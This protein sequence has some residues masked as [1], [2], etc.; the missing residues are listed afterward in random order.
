LGDEFVARK[1]VAAE[2]VEHVFVPLAKLGSQPLVVAAEGGEIFYSARIRVERPMTGEVLDHGL[3]VKR[4]Y[5]N[6][7]DNEPMGSI[8]L[9]QQVLVRITVSSPMAHAHVAVVD[10]LP[11]GFE[12]VLSRFSNDGESQ[13]HSTG[14]A[15]SAASWNTYWQNEELRDDRMQVFADTLSKGASTHDYLVRAASTGTFVAAPTSAEAMY[16]P[17]VQGRSSARTVEIVK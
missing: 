12:P 15:Y 2:A 9:G 5:L 1:T 16:D 11:A 3:E 14:H 6:P 4:E 8:T 13:P 10:R 17:A 7:E